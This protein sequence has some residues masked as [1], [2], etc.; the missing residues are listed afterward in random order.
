MA[1]ASGPMQQLCM[2]PDRLGSWVMQRA[3][4]P[5]KTS[6]VRRLRS[7]DTETRRLILGLKARPTT[8]PVWPESTSSSLRVFTD[9][10]KIWNVSKDPAE[11]I[12]DEKRSQM[13]SVV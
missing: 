10:T 5:S 9:Q 3:P 4:L 13:L 12:C 2:R 7:H 8:G 1:T 11:T 6:H